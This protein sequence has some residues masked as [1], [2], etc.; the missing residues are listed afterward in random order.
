[1][2]LRVDHGFMIGGRAQ[3]GKALMVSQPL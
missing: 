1:V 3:K 2:L